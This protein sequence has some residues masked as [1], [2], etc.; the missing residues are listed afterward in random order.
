LFGFSLHGRWAILEVET[1]DEYPDWVQAYSAGLLEGSLTWQLIYW[2]WQN[3]V[4]NICENQIEFCKH[5]RSFVE[6]NSEN[7]KDVAE[8]KGDNDPFWHQVWYRELRTC[9]FYISCFVVTEPLN[10]ICH[11]NPVN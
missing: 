4:Q 9:F 3:T 10:F 7:V 6:I 1:R 8:K 11:L 5:V 2:H